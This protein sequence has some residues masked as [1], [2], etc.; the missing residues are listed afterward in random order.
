LGKLEK[1][2]QKIRDSAS[3]ELSPKSLVRVLQVNLG[4]AQN[5]EQ[6]LNFFRRCA[7]FGEMLVASSTAFTPYLTFPRVR[8]SSNLQERVGTLGAEAA[9]PLAEEP[10]APRFQ[11]LSQFE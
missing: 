2:L 3:V 10:D 11:G 1:S 6:C 4:F 8:A 5:S 9:D 7:D